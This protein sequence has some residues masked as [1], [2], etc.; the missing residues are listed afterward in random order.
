MANP[1]PHRASA[2]RAPICS[3]TIPTT[4]PPIGIIPQY[5]VA[6][7]ATIRPRSRA[8]EIAWVNVRVAAAKVRKLAPT[9]GSTAIASGAPGTRPN[10]VRPIA[11]PNTPQNSARPWPI[12]RW[13]VSSDTPA[14]RPPMPTATN[15]MPRPPAPIP[16]SS[17]ATGS[18]KM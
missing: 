4:I 12:R 7:R 1:A 3:A 13:I 11:A 9:I 16:S 10:A 18:M 6:N 15:S 2:E 14:T 17:A 5:R 8:G